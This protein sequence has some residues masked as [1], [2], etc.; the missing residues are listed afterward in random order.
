MWTPCIYSKLRI[1]PTLGARMR[2]VSTWL[3]LSL[4]VRMWLSSPWSH[5]RQNWQRHSPPWR[6]LVNRVA[7]RPFN[8]MSSSTLSTLHSSSR[9]YNNCRTKDRWT[10][11]IWSYSSFKMP[12]WIP[13]NNLRNLIQRNALMF[14]NN[15]NKQLARCS[16]QIMPIPQFLEGELPAAKESLNH[17]SPNLKGITWVRNPSPPTKWWFSSL[18][19]L[20]LVVWERQQIKRV[21]FFTHLWMIPKLSWPVSKIKI[22]PQS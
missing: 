18:L 4:I 22:W 11:K 3:W 12:P 20:V 10:C 6:H 19:L 9:S 7:S 8:R 21:S 16:Q 15:A 2:S 13:K 14:C 17:F 5:T 1:R